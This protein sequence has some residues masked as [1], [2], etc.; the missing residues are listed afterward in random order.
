MEAS[1]AGPRH[2]HFLPLLLQT[3]TEFFLVDGWKGAKWLLPSIRFG[4][5]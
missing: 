2:L 1:K 3:I 5:E 4:F